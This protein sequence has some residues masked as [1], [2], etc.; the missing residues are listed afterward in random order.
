[1]I[2]SRILL[3][4]TAAIAA[5][6]AAGWSYRRWTSASD[7][8]ELDA[9]LGSYFDRLAAAD[10]FSGAAQIVTNGRVVLDRKSYPQGS[11][12]TSR[13]RASSRIYDRQRLVGR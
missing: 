1:M 9:A 6:G 10:T 2:T 4:S 11:L 5:V 13:T 12:A 7:N 8:A 3:R